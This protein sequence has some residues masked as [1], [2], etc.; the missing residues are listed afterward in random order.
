MTTTNPL[1][2][3][4]PDY[5]TEAHRDADRGQELANELEKLGINC[6]LVLDESCQAIFCG[7][8]YRSQMT[9][10]VIK[11]SKS[12]VPVFHYSWDIYPFQ[13]ESD[14]TLWLPYIEQLKAC[15]EIWVPT[16]SCVHRC[17]QY[18]GRMPHV[19]HPAFKPYSPKP[20]VTYGDY[21]VDVVRKYPDPN[22]NLCREVCD[23]LGIKCI[24]TDCKMPWEEFK[25]TIAG[26]RLLVS[27]QYEASTGGLTLLEG[28][29]LGKRCLVSN[30]PFNGASEFSVGFW[31]FYWEARD[32]FKKEL[33]ASVKQGSNY[34]E[35]PQ[36]TSYFSDK[37]MASRIANRLRELVE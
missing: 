10:S 17:L 27:A 13:V 3:W 33:N 14:P 16:F 37:E 8:V 11:Y 24:E 31:T 23:E 28:T 7:S 30:S 32:S 35:D 26:A 25:R 2:I 22:A 6:S 5:Y 34:R 29:Q 12:K 21:V 1:K 19:I 15:R 20:E 18:C 4:F 9:T 36:L